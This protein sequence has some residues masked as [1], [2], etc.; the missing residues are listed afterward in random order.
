MVVRGH[1]GHAATDGL[2]QQGDEVAGDEEAWIRHRF[3][4]GIGL[5]HRDH[6]ARQGEVDAGGEEGGG[7]GQTDNLHQKSVL[8]NQTLAG[9]GL[10]HV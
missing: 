10:R 5:P 6:D 9:S 4:A 1:A 7:N 3:D 8:P 2:E